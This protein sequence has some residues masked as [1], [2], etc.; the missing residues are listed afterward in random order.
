MTQGYP[1]LLDV[2]SRLI[3]IVGGG[4]VA[5]RK[6]QGL[7]AAG[8]RHVRCVSPEF[9][10]RMP[11]E[12][13]R[14]AEYFDE[15]HL[16]GASLVFAA[17]NSPDV[18]RQVVAAAQKRGLLVNRADGDDDRPGDFTV[19]AVHRHQAVNIAV[20]AG[21]SPALAAKI[22]DELAKQLDPALLQMAQAME[23]LRP[24]MKEKMPPDRRREAFRELAGAQAISILSQR[25]ADGLIAWLADKYIEMKA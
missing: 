20:W 18:N 16:N 7:L 3:L 12:I 8:A 2:S 6:A 19:P 21:G 1:L 4:A 11:G 15:S 22:R 9:D 5:V 17:T 14:I 25:G 24:L 10:T 13:E 23:I